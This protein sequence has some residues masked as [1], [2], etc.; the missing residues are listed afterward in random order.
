MRQKGKTEDDTRASR[1][2]SDSLPLVSIPSEEEESA[3]ERASS[4]VWRDSSA[5]NFHEQPG[6]QEQNQ[7][8]AT[9]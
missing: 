2:A 4:I 1:S 6:R 5:I 3:S 7:Q 9:H 8:V